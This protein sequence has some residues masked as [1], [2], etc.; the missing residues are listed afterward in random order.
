MWEVHKAWGM[1]LNS[2]ALLTQE[3]AQSPVPLPLAH[4]EHQ[5][6]TREQVTSHELPAASSFS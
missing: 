4:P 3:N 5:G 1:Q 6:K 2:T